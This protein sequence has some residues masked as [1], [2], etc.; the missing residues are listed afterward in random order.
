[1][2]DFNAA[3]RWSRTSAGNNIVAK[4]KVAHAALDSQIIKDTDPFVPYRYGFLAKSALLSRE[5]GLI[6]YAMPYA[7][8]CYYGVTFR[9]RKS[10]HPQATHHWLERSKAIWLK[11]WTRIVTYFLMQ[12]GN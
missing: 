8:R 6:R 1:L 5:V 9:F 12:R 7:K 10:K 11:Q 4:K 3:F 2:I